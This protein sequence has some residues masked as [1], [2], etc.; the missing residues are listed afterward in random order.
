MSGCGFTFPSQ[1]TPDR[2]GLATGS[3]PA[4]PMS[5]ATPPLPAVSVV[6]GHIRAHIRRVLLS[7]GMSG[8]TEVAA[9][10][11]SELST[12]AVLASQQPNRSG[13]D[14]V[15]RSPAISICLYG[16]GTQLR[17]EVWD[18]AAGLP[19]LSET[20][21]D[22]ECGRGLALIDALTESR[23]GWQLAD[24]PWASKC[25]WAEISAPGPMTTSDQ[26]TSFVCHPNPQN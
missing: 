9:L 12:N 22:A 7:W 26:P 6:P 19:A 13:N 15:A 11:A 5:N 10:V 21:V 23:W 17:I 2:F 25:V 1:A 8:L 14:Q 20:P 24:H 4:W 16:D 18:Q 3:A